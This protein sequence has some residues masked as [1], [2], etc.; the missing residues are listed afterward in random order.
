MK[1]EAHRD[2]SEWIDGGWILSLEFGP[3]EDELV[4]LTTDEALRASLFGPPHQSLLTTLQL[5]RNGT[6]QGLASLEVTLPDDQPLGR[7]RGR[8][9]CFHTVGRGLWYRIWPELP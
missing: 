1:L 5:N 9:R 7:V 4:L 2:L 3:R 8:G 6:S